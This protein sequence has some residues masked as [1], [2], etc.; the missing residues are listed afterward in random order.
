M[1]IE[2][3]NM[4][5]TAPKTMGSSIP[6][7]NP[8]ERKDTWSNEYSQ[9]QYDLVGQTATK[10]M[11]D[12]QVAL[13]VIKEK[14]QESTIKVAELAAG[15][16]PISQTLSRLG[17]ICTAIEKNNSMTRDNGIPYIEKDLCSL[18]PDPGTK[19]SFD[20]A[21]I[22]NGWYAV[23]TPEDSAGESK[24]TEQEA[25]FLRE[26]SLSNMWSMLKEDGTLI[27]N[28]PL[29]SSQSINSEDIAKGLAQEIK[30]QRL[31]QKSG[32]LKF[33]WFKALKDTVTTFTQPE[34]REVVESNR[35][36]TQ[37][38]HFFRSQHEM[39][40]F[41]E[42]SGLFT[43]NSSENGKYLGH[44]VQIIAEK[45]AD[46]EEKRKAWTFKGKINRP[47]LQKIGEFR[48][49][50]YTDGKVNPNVPA[51]D[52]YDLK[53]EGVLVAITNNGRLELA[54]TMQQPGSKGLEMKDLMKLAEGSATEFTEG[55]I[56]QAQEK[57]PEIE[58][59]IS[60][61]LKIGVAE[62]RRL[63]SERNDLKKAKKNFPI[64]YKEMT[65]Y[66]EEED[67][68]LITMVTTKKKAR[69]FNHMLKEEETFKGFEIL[70]GYEIKRDNLEAQTLLITGADYFLDEWEKQMKEYPMQRILISNLRSQIRNGDTWRETIAHLDAHEQQQYE[71]AVN[72]LLDITPDGIN[73][74]Y[75]VHQKSKN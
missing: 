74:Y 40:D 58:N 24:L 39:D 29:I 72:R 47:L 7:V 56:K 43:I 41:I 17:Y 34:F 48:K 59:A 54:A 49:K 1:S 5:N 32:L 50:A 69:F 9:E 14:G 45:N 35:R 68:T 33:S 62:V 73:V 19:E 21:T 36:I 53:E 75:T 28:D 46:P 10:K 61:G 70:P 42:S 64:L 13:A 25:L 27:I 65:Q 22:V 6:E 4:E 66:A 30:N 37:E 44:N 71:D 23:T 63:A 2:L 26:A 55:L 12:L 3:P 51:I 60:K 38:C 18:V 20:I 8:E 52:D 57:S 16:A 11:L 31:L 15:P 67:I